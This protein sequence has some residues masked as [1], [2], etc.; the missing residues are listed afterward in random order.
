MDLDKYL[1][2]TQ[3]DKNERNKRATSTVALEKHLA[4]RLL[5]FLL[6]HENADEGPLFS[7]LAK[8]VDYADGWR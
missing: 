7:E 5:T 2:Q 3:I 1:T 8:A 4:D 6:K